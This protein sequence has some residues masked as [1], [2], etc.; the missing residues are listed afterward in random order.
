MKT[1]TKTC[2]KTNNIKTKEGFI[3]FE[4][5]KQRL[6]GKKDLTYFRSV[7]IILEVF[8]GQFNMIEYKVQDEKTGEV[9]IHGTFIKV[10]EIFN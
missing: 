5:Y 7:D 10:E 9:R 6:E 2:T 1:L 4:D 8:K 3:T